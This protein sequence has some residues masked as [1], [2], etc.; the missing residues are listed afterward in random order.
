MQEPQSLTIEQ[1][2][3]F[4][5]LVSAGYSEDQA[6]QALCP[7]SIDTLPIRYPLNSPSSFSVE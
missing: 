4:D 5:Y 1:Q 3:K 6:Y 7:L 2:L